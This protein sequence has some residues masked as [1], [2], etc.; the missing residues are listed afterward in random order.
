M[1]ITSNGRAKTHSNQLSITTSM[2]TLKN[3]KYL[4]SKLRSSKGSSRV[5]DPNHLAQAKGAHPWT[6]PE[7]KRPTKRR[8]RLRSYKNSRNSRGIFLEPLGNLK[9]K[10]SWLLATTIDLQIPSLTRKLTKQENKLKNTRRGML[11]RR[12]RR[13]KNIGSENKRSRNS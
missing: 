3:C 13:K 11:S 9:K 12:R 8:I 5:S 6:L 4:K 2:K 1:R 10:W 7:E